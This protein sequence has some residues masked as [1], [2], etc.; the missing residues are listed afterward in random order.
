MVIYMDLQKNLVMGKCA[1]AR[2][3]VYEKLIS[4]IFYKYYQVISTI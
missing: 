1:N 4:N 2:Y 3:F